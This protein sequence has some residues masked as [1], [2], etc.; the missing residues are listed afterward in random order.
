[1]SASPT[2]HIIHADMDAFYASVEQYD[3]PELRGQ[4]VLV[5]GSPKARGVV[6]AASYES[7]VFGCRSAMPMK[8]A[9]RLCPHAAIVSPR[10]DRYR[11]ISGQVM[12]IFRSVT[13]LVEPLSLD[14]AFL[15]VTQRVQ[16]GSSP[17]NVGQ[18]IKNQVREKTGL[19]ISCGVAATKSVAKIASD[20]DKPD[21]LTVVA[22]GTERAF[23][24]PLSVR[25]LW[26]VGPKTAERLTKAGVTTIGE[27][28][29]R[30]LPWLIER[31]G[32]RGEWFHRLAVGDDERGIETSRETKSI[33]SETTFAE[34]VGDLDALA[35]PAKEQ[36]RSVAR[37]LQRAEL[38]ARTVQ[39]KL[40]LS[41]FTTFTRQRT[42][43]APTNEAA[44]IEN[45]ALALLGEQVGNGR[46]FRL[47]GVGASNLLHQEAFGQLSLF[48][49]PAPDEP[50]PHGTPTDTTDPDPK[51]VQPPT[52]SGQPTAGDQPKAPP[53]QRPASPT[54]PPS[55][56]RRS[57]P[58]APVPKKPASQTARSKG[59]TNTVSAMREKF[60]DDAVQWGQGQGPP[61]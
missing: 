34:D 18:W 61:T 3:R 14:E 41:D 47:I 2:R 15:D 35:E 42:L 32:V 23:L 17:Q 39:I 5:G 60:G 51:Q 27:L 28:A 8:T 54:A 4:P 16:S 53:S 11:E 48:E 59:L 46:R 45:V 43:P 30:P 24:A 56:K 6:A 26:G 21:G 49:G 1:M 13:P 20:M 33:S 9:V 50:T 29:E 22:P 58:T 52:P 40:R 36:A 10:F 55:P 37:R 25:D 38:R 31:F 12:D 7:R 19:T 57:R 44:I